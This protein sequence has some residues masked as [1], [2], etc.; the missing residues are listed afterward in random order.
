MLKNKLIVDLAD[1]YGAQTRALSD[2][3]D[4]YPYFRIESLRILN[5]VI[6]EAIAGHRDLNK[7]Y[8][9]HFFY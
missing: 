2:S 4:R 8:P 6:D 3:R 7:Q 1:L 9:V 5:L